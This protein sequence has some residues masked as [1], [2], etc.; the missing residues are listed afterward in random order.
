MV[1]LPTPAQSAPNLPPTRQG[2]EHA[3]E[4]YGMSVQTPV[5]QAMK[6]N[7]LSLFNEARGE[8]QLP[9]GFYQRFEQVIRDS[10][11]AYA[12]DVSVLTTPDQQALLREGVEAYLNDYMPDLMNILRTRTEKWR[13]AGQDD[14]AFGEQRV[15][16]IVL[17]Q[18]RVIR[19][20]VQLCTDL[21]MKEW[22]DVA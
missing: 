2:T 10:L 12:D 17:H 14:R 20:A 16:T 5:E 8:V 13:R 11:L 9:Q 3:D 7:L 15:D 21:I 18:T 22:D 1:T 6:A 19:T 4:R